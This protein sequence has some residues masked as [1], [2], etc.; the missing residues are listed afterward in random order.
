MSRKGHDTKILVDD[1]VKLTC[2]GGGVDG[3]CH[4]ILSGLPGGSGGNACAFKV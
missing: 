1:E 3:I 2:K 4:E